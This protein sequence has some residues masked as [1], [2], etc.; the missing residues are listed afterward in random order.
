MVG[1]RKEST[2]SL[3]TGRG[4]GKGSGQG[5][6]QEWGRGANLGQFYA[7]DFKGSLNDYK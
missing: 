1:G 3:S 4:G 7:L 2:G 6:S 5:W